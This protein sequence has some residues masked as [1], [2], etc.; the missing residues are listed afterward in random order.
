MPA[1][2]IPVSGM[3]CAACQSF[4]QRTL[5]QQPGVR[6]AAVNLM[7]Q[8]ATVTYEPA[9]TS[10]ERLVDA[11]R[12][13]GYGAEMPAA[14]HSAL[15]DQEQQE[16]E[17]SREFMRLR[18]KAGVSLV[19]GAV[20]MV[21]SMPLMS[22]GGHGQGSTTDPL[23]RWSM[24]T[25]DP[26]LRAWLPWLY[27]PSPAFWS[28]FLLV[29]TAAVMFWAGRHFYTKA[30]AALRL[31]S[32]DM[33]TLIALGTG[34]AFVF[35]ASATLAPSFFVARGVAPDVYYEAVILIIALVLVGNTLEGRATRR[36]SAALRKLVALQ[37]KTARVLRSG[38]EQDVPIEQIRRNDTVL[39]RPGERIPVDGVVLSGAS[40]VDESMLTGESMPLE[41][42]P[43]ARLIGGT[44]NQSGA[45]RFE[46]NTVG[47]ESVLAHVVRLLR[48]AQGSRAPIQKLADRISAIFAPAVVGAAV[49]TFV[50]W[51]FLAPGTPVFHAVAAAVAVLIIACPCAMGLAVPTAVMVATGR[52]ADRGI[53]IKGGEALQRLEAVDTVVLDKTGT[54]TRGQP[55]VTDV[56]MLDSKLSELELLR[57]AGSLEKSS[58]HP[59]AAAVARYASERNLELGDA[60]EFQA[61]PGKGAV[62][63]VRGVSVAIGNASLMESLGVPAD[64]AEAERLAQDGKTP[65]LVSVEGQLAAVIGVADT[66]K[67][68]SAGAVREL[69]QMGMRVLLLTGDKERTARAVGREVGI[70]EVVAGVL[71]AGKLDEVKRLQAQGRVVAMAGDGINDAPA[72]AQADVGI[73]MGSGADVAVDAGDVT[74]MRSDPQGIV[75]AIRLARGAMRVMRQNLFWAFLYNSVGIPIAAGVLYPLW[76]LQVSPVLASAA[77]AFSSV[78]VV[79]NSLRLGRK[80]L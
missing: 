71:P 17:Q 55:A 28:Y 16:R 75:E 5:E 77:M 80:Q 78:S 62:G 36:T 79:T 30:W 50:G 41:K 26:V 12:E 3:T 14:G 73:A 66:V 70:E 61:Q 8:N 25:L 60:E 64:V 45:L 65:L 10:P 24:H 74:L 46:A 29:L 69:R 18:R 13:T 44:L 76:G 2:Q 42:A 27:L 51:R 4:V 49:L 68:S 19:A 7:T 67:P 20:A 39:V 21:V 22:A 35:S 6:T 52:G 63:K 37:P 11:I 59:L 48:E 33:N 1:I 47:A 56:L 40:S 54:I 32:A 53:L 23:L 34:A 72:L 31:R 38:A 9:E 15:E 43:G 57:L 58:E